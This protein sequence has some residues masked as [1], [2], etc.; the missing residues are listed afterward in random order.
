MGVWPYA[1]AWLSPMMSRTK[2]MYYLSTPPCTGVC[3]DT[4]GSLRAYLL[5]PVLYSDHASVTV[6]CPFVSHRM[7]PMM[8]P[9]MQLTLLRERWGQKVE[10]RAHVIANYLS[11]CVFCTVSEVGHSRSSNRTR[12]QKDMFSPRF[13]VNSQTEVGASLTKSAQDLCLRA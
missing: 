7:G 13:N 2:R 3:E 11:N 12:A 10:L 5:P 1:R 6:V 8:L 9:D 4:L